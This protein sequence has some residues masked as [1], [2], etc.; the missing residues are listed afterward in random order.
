MMFIGLNPSTADETLD[1]PTIRRCVGFAKQ[2]GYGGIFM[3]N[4][5]A[6]R[7]PYPRAV[8]TEAKPIGPDNDNL[9]RAYDA[10]A[11]TVV[12]CWGYQP[13]AV[14]RAMSV[15]RMLGDLWCFGRTRTGQPRH[16][17]Y[18]PAGAELEPL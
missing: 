11:A 14:G 6:F 2:Y 18:L 5:F 10:V 13:W 3:L 8:K 9:L 4:L 1:D 17:L 12:A 7:S 16:P 15:R